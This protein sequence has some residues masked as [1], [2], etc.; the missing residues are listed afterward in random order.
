MPRKRK[1]PP[2]T[3]ENGPPKKKP[4][5]EDVLKEA[6]PEW[7]S[8]H[9][10]RELMRQNIHYVLQPELED[11]G[12]QY[13]IIQHAK[14]NEIL[15][16]SYTRYCQVTDLFDPIEAFP[17]T[18]CNPF[19]R[20][21]GPDHLYAQYKDSVIRG[22]MA[23]KRKSFH[24]REPIRLK[25]IN[26]DRILDA[27]RLYEPSKQ[28]II[29][30]KMMGTTP[31]EES[32]KYVL[33]EHQKLGI[34][35]LIREA[36][37]QRVKLSISQPISNLEPVKNIEE[38]IYPDLR[39]RIIEKKEL[40]A[41]KALL[42]QGVE[43]KLEVTIT[44]DAETREV[45]DKSLSTENGPSLDS[46]PELEIIEEE[47]TDEVPSCT[48]QSISRAQSKEVAEPDL[49]EATISLEPI[50]DLPIELPSLEQKQLDQ[51]VDPGNCLHPSCYHRFLKNL[52]QQDC[53]DSRN[54]L[55]KTESYAEVKQR[56]EE[57]LKSG[58]FRCVFKDMRRNPPVIVLAP[59]PEMVNASKFQFFTDEAQFVHSL[60]KA[61]FR[62][63]A[64]NNNYIIV[65]LEGIHPQSNWIKKNPPKGPVKA[66][67][68]SVI[69][70]TDP[71]GF[72][73]EIQCLFDGYAF[74]GARI[75]V[76][77]LDL[78]S[79]PN[80][81]KVGS[82][83]TQDLVTLNAIFSDFR[84][85]FHPSMEVSQL[86]ML[87][88]PVNKNDLKRGEKPPNGKEAVAQYLGLGHLLGNDPKI[89]F[90][91]GFNPN[92]KR[93]FDDF[94]Q[95]PRNWKTKMFLYNRL[96][97][98]LGLAMIDR[99]VVKLAK[100]YHFPEQPDKDIGFLRLSVFALLAD[101]TV[102]EKDSVTVGKFVIPPMNIFKGYSPFRDYLD[103]V[104]YPHPS[105][106]MQNLHRLI[107][108]RN[109]QGLPMIFGGEW[110]ET[111]SLASYCNPRR[112][113]SL[114]I[115]DFKE[116]PFPHS[117]SECYSYDHLEEN[118]DDMELL[119]EECQYPLC[120]DSF[121]TH[122]IRNCPVL[123]HRCTICDSLGHSDKHHQMEGFDVLNGLATYRGFVQKHRFAGIIFSR[124]A[125][126]K[127]DI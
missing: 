50:K 47:G 13:M 63:N 113:W 126:S 39:D 115:Q 109:L 5:I 60:E 74:Q 120:H 49:P 32:L 54:G 23:K 82:G 26:E 35:N 10:E 91:V 119:L 125:I 65:D 66:P 24:A 106:I 7:T 72:S 103:H 70:F 112:N 83:I 17:A 3:G 29:H 90:Q 53:E 104:G 22:K 101:F 40:K 118:C 14:N 37:Y 87:L 127:L 1:N 27:L 41:R 21:L 64:I 81:V 75:P 42:D 36:E 56:K 52:S 55:L 25:C 116:I 15:G 93:S 11:D 58:K 2:C 107:G 98:F 89:S 111:K 123:I 4:T 124:E 92:N 12:N 68:I 76:Y 51:C 6:P 59:N 18:I 48:E 9:K 80:I 30:C 94:T 71:K 16:T 79:N 105:V 86:L 114:T 77:L 19:V 33:S 67:T 97:R 69:H 95:N 110:S 38:S 28:W 45:N 88:N 96:D 99:A 62:E 43:V 61:R 102:F 121:K 57:N 44:K 122:T 85:K 46:T 8:M 100:L 84:R 117:C 78:L 31:Y 108:N 34:P 73:C 20:M